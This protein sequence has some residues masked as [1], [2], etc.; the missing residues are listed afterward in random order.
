MDVGSP[1]Q[2]TAG[3]GW[4]ARLGLALALALLA[5]A[6]GATA[7]TPATD[8]G[9][10]QGTDRMDPSG[11]GAVIG[12]KFGASAMLSVRVVD[13]SGTARAGVRVDFSLAGEAGGS[14]LGA[15]TSH[16]DESGEAGVTVRAGHREASFEV[17][18]SAAGV[19]KVIFIVSVSELDFADLSVRA[20][21]PAEL[22]SPPSKVV[23]RL[24]DNYAC[25]DLPASA[26]PPAPPPRTI[27][28]ALD[29][30]VSFATLLPSRA[31]AVLIVPAA[32]AAGAAGCVDVLPGRLAAGATT[33][34]LIPLHLPAPALAS[35]YALVTRV[36]LASVPELARP[37]GPLSCPNAPGELILDCLIDAASLADDPDGIDCVP[38]L[39]DRADALGALLTAHRADV[40]NGCRGDAADSGLDALVRTQL[41]A[42]SPALAHALTELGRAAVIAAA[43]GELRLGSELTV[44]P[45]GAAD[46]FVGRHTLLTASIGDPAGL[47]FDIDLAAADLPQR[48]ADGVPLLVGADGTLSVGAHGLSLRF[49]TLARRALAKLVLEPNGL[50]ADSQELLDALLA[51][52]TGG[53]GDPCPALGLLVCTAVGLDPQCLG[54]RCAA[55]LAAAP[56]FLDAPL[57]R[58]DGGADLTLA[59][60]AAPQGEAS[61]Q[62]L[63]GGSWSVALGPE[64]HAVTVAGTFSGGPV[65]TPLRACVP[66]GEGAR[67][68]RER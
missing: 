56:R 17:H 3:A 62:F 15:G 26:P 7:A 60:K 38:S 61:G 25:A 11:S 12:L 24:Y 46:R 49:G 10:T 59:G 30:T 31:Y 5:S 47:A 14:A 45:A 4:A 63:T 28:A 48:A 18:A 43:L 64:S 23:I 9:P 37:L 29:E 55:A 33:L 2:I 19:P 42:A 22:A 32:G 58:F 20:S 52:F 1:T 51:A 40:V 53:A 35:R 16:T 39:A 67:T 68:N 21:V 57:A 36:P 13:A 44:L 6:C 34:V 41:A 50:P 8:G 27:G 54:S 65:P 66:G